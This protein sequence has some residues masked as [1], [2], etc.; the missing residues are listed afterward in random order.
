MN[1][2]APVR[3]GWDSKR[4]VSRVINATQSRSKYWNAGNERNKVAAKNKH[5]FKSWM[6]FYIAFIVSLVAAGADNGTLADSSSV[7]PGSYPTGIHSE[8]MF[9]SPTLEQTRRTD[10]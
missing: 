4:K 6:L 1:R 7:S 10:I 2:R 3:P 8:K 5:P 9:F